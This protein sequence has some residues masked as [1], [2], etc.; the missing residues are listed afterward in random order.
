MRNK[1]IPLIL[2]VVTFPALSQVEQESKDH[3]ETFSPTLLLQ[4]SGTSF[5]ENYNSVDVSVIKDISPNR[6][7]GL[8]LGYIF[9]YYGFN[10]SNTIEADWFKNVNGFK[11]YFQYRIYFNKELEYLNNSR[12]FLDLEPGFFWMNYDSERIVGYQC[13]D[14]FGDCLYY[15]YFNSEINQFAPRFN[16][17]IG[18]IYDFESLSITVFG[19]LGLHHIF[20][21][22]DMPTNPKPDKYFFKNGEM[23][24]KLSSG[25]NLN[26]RVGV[27]VGYRFN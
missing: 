15:R 25:T 18:K 10:N 14:E 16:V 2:M 21:K 3:K 8:E 9:D 4:I 20:E 13:N 24:D 19:G 17:K 6:A 12:T 11:A 22:S 7:I 23:N 5:F 1:L 27:Q 26:F